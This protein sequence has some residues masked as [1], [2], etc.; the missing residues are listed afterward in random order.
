M[1]DPSTLP[2]PLRDG[3]KTHYIKGFYNHPKGLT[4]PPRGFFPWSFVPS[5]YS[6]PPRKGGG[7]PPSRGVPP[8]RGGGTPPSRGGTPPRGGTPRKPEKSRFFRIF[9]KF[10]KNPENPEFSCK[11]GVQNALIGPRLTVFLTGGPE[12]PKNREKSRFFGIFGIFGIFGVFRAP[13][14]KGGGYPPPSGGTPLRGGGTPPLL[15]GPKAESELRNLLP[16]VR[17]CTG[18][19]RC[20]GA[21][22][23]RRWYT[24]VTLGAPTERTP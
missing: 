7:A 20:A 12:I 15:G 6:H 13:P 11:I 8:E 21:R 5:A 23:D 3:R 16:S 18:A 17:H 2:P 24:S 4:T 1:S 14:R 19:S 22:F 10:R 9:R